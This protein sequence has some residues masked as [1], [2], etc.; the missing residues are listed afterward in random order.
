[1]SGYCAGYKSYF[2][3]LDL[4][5][6]AC[7][8]HGIDFILPDP[9]YTVLQTKTAIAQL[10]ARRLKRKAKITAVMQAVRNEE[11][12]D[13]VPLAYDDVDQRI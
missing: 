11:L 9:A 6:I 2:D 10:K 13:W 7:G 8:E 1:M 4:F 5:S 12:N 3:W